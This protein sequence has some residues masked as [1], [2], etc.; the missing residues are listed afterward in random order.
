M[1]PMTWK[2]DHASLACVICLQP[3]FVRGDGYVDASP[4]DQV[5][6]PCAEQIAAALPGAAAPRARRKQEVAA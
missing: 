6:R 2:T 4:A 3:V 1:T 5:C